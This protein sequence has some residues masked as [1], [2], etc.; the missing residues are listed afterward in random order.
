MLDEETFGFDPFVMQKATTKIKLFN[1]FYSFYIKKTSLS[2]FE[3]VL[4]LHSERLELITGFRL[5]FGDE[6]FVVFVA[7]DGIGCLFDKSLELVDVEFVVAELFVSVLVTS[8]DGFDE[9]GVFPGLVVDAT[10]ASEVLV[11]VGILAVVQFKQRS[12]FR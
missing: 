6:S 7:E 12:P 8:V 5:R 10:E 9:V 1:V 4:W 3:E 11:A 2:T